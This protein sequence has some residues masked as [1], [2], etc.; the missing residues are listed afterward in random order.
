MIVKTKSTNNYD[1]SI[2]KTESEP[3]AAVIRTGRGLTIAGTRITLYAIMDYLELDWPLKLIRN[4][5]NLT[6]AQIR[7]AIDYIAAHRE[8]C[9]AEY[10]AVVEQ[11]EKNRHYWE[12]YNRSQF[13]EIANLPPKPGRE[14]IKAKLQ[15]RKKELDMI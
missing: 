12:E 15:A 4:R 13:A 10:Q 8:E 5:L 14:A 6:D 2:M 7:A 9:E 3:Q 11:A 1:D